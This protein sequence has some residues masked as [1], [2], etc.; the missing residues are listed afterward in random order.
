[1]LFNSFGYRL[2]SFLIET[3]ADKQ[4]EAK[5]DANDYDESKLIEIRI[6]LKLPY[7]TE[8][9]EFER[10]NGEIE[11]NG[12]YYKYVKR[13]VI[14]DSLILLCLP[15]KSKHNIVSARDHFFELVNGLKHPLEKKSQSSSIFKTL[16]S[17]YI[18]ED[19]FWTLPSLSGDKKEYLIKNSPIKSLFN[20]QKL[21]KPPTFV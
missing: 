14:T 19:C 18:K 20:Y 3:K 16:L 6:P 13:K 10:F 9:K 12:T 2:F 15:N 17:D 5:L 8:W 21:I 4:V 7:T 11:L 1:M